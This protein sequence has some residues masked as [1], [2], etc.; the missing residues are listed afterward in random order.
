ML[1]ERRARRPQSNSGFFQ[2]TAHPGDGHARDASVAAEALLPTIFS[3]DR[4]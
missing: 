2:I 3:W 4:E 1:H